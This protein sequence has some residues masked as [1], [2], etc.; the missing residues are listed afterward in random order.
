VQQK[1]AAVDTGYKAVR[2]ET[3]DAKEVR[4][5]QAKQKAGE[6]YEK[7]R[8]VTPG[9]IAA[10]YLK[11]H[12][13][14]TAEPGADIKTSGVWDRS[15]K[16]SYPALM[17]F[18]RNDEGKITGGQSILLDPTNN[19]K[20]DIEEVNKFFGSIRGSFVCLQE[21]AAFEAKKKITDVDSVIENFNHRQKDQVTF[22]AESVETALSVK[23]AGFEGR[24]LCSLGIYNIRNYE[25][26]EG[27]KII[28]VAD[29]AGKET[30]AE[31]HINKTGEILRERGAAVLI[32]KP[33]ETGN[34]SDM[35]SKGGISAVK[36]DLVTAVKGLQAE[37]HNSTLVRLETSLFRQHYEPE[38]ER[39]ERSQLQAKTVGEVMGYITAKHQLAVKGARE[40]TTKLD[41]FPQVQFNRRQFVEDPALMKQLESEVSFIEKMDMMWG[42][43]LLHFLQRE[44]F[45][46]LSCAQQLQKDC[47]KR[48]NREIEE[49]EQEYR[50]HGGVRKEIFDYNRHVPR[51]KEEFNEYR[52]YLQSRGLES[53]LSP[54]Q[55]KKL[56][57]IENTLF[58]HTWM[59]PGYL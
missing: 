17:A 16:K 13:G 58:Q 1:E 7:A 53:E 45:Y 50:E 40:F 32:V 25:P 37:E 59:E 44:K 9:S 31:K 28:I 39:L 21:G 33:K 29:N 27:E 6:S 51:K 5:Q 43:N 52:Q 19:N 35:L 36:S 55:Q 56:Q 20:A 26:K 15:T 57:Y 2:V 48:V 18:A 12:R 14:I 47:M 46:P 42:D 10:K 30:N 3:E 41:N 8:Q 54:E 38:F 22:L 34:Y 23:Q 4:R 49:K 24:I 11:E